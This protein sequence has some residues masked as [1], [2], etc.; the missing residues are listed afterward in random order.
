MKCCICQKDTTDDFVCPFKN[1]VN[2]AYSGYKSFE[3]KLTEFS[4]LG[5]IPFNVNLERLSD[6]IESTLQKNSAKWHKRCMLHFTNDKLERARKR[7]SSIPDLPIVPKK[8][9][10]SRRSTLQ[11]V[12]MKDELFL[13]KRLHRISTF[14]D[15]KREECADVTLNSELKSYLQLGGDLVSKEAKYHLSCYTNLTNNS[16][17]RTNTSDESLCQYIAFVNVVRHV[18]QN[19]EAADR[20]EEEV[21]SS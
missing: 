21:V 1:P 13:G 17:K 6:G 8:L 14:I 10:R 9:K 19:V 2:N 11:T 5:E 18:S 3:G 20:E 12:Q 15:D 7:K 4:K 16:S